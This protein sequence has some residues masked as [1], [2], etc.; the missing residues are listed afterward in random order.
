MRLQILHGPSGSLSPLPDA[1]IW[2]TCLRDIGFVDGDDESD[3]PA[4]VDRLDDAPA[5]ALLLEV[6]CGLRSP[7]AGETQVMG[8]FKA[9]VKALG[10]DGDRVRRLAQRVLTDAREI[11][12]DH[13][14]GLGAR[15]YG[16]QVKRHVRGCRVVALIGAGALATE[17]APALA[18]AADVHAWNRAVLADPGR[19]SGVGG[20][21]RS[22]RG[23]ARR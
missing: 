12:T 16:S 2:R 11:R 19:R 22:R 9:F 20:T 17:I 10:S 21:G 4:G 3:L 13:L 8:Q 18:D 5:Y 14:Q 15:A 1:V 6:V 23:G 7:L